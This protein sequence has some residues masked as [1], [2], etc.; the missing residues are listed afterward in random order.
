MDVAAELLSDYV[1]ENPAIDLDSL[2][3]QY[4]GVALLQRLKYISDHCPSLRVEALKLAIKSVKHTLDVNLYK[5]LHTL[6]VQTCNE[7]TLPDIT[8]DF[9]MPV[10]NQTCVFFV[11]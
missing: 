5:Q 3:N 9:A 8:A 1:V 6:L 4:E 10:S 7:N 2:T 11:F